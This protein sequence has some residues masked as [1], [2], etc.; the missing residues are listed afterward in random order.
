M[1]YDTRVCPLTGTLCAPSIAQNAL[2]PV[3]LLVSDVRMKDSHASGQKAILGAN[4][5][6]IR[7]S[8]YCGL[9]AYKIII[10][11]AFSAVPGNTSLKPNYW[12]LEPSSKGNGIKMVPNGIKKVPDHW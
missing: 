7:L 2:L 12:S 11:P 6:L 9:P 4:A 1:E 3:T 10:L 8:T 5:H